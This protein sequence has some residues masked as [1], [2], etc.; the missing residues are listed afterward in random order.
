VKRTSARQEAFLANRQN[1]AI[2]SSP[3][4]F[5]YPSGNGYWLSGIMTGA[6]SFTTALKGAVI[7][8]C[9]VGSAHGFSVAAA[10]RLMEGDV[11]CK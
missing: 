4:K 9:R 2:G 10:T 8:F 6:E 1:L 3:F 7:A 5:P 11:A